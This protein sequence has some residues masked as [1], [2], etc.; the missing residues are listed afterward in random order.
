MWRIALIA[1]FVFMAIPRRTALAQSTVA[2]E[3]FVHY[4]VRGES[5]WRIA[6]QRYCAIL[7]E[8]RSV[9]P[10][11]LQVARIWRVIRRSNRRRGRLIDPHQ[12][13]VGLLLRLPRVSGFSFASAGEPDRWTCSSMIAISRQ[14]PQPTDATQLLGTDERPQETVV[15]VPSPP[16]HPPPGFPMTQRPASVSGPSGSVGSQIA[17]GPALFAD[18]GVGFRVGL[19]SGIRL[20]YPPEVA[21]FEGEVGISPSQS[22]SWYFTAHGSRSSA[23]ATP[24][25]FG[26]ER[27]SLVRETSLGFRGGYWLWQPGIVRIGPYV[28]L[29]GI[30]IDRKV[31]LAGYDLDESAF[32][33]GVEAGAAAVACIPLPLN[34]GGLLGARS[35]FVF[36]HVPINDGASDGLWYQFDLFA[37]VGSR[38]SR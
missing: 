32:G 7:G 9:R 23:L 25:I 13:P 30:W 31:A 2:V 24:L 35:T 6:E 3:P 34:M 19:L 4:V 33:F 21:V 22:R 5:F 28:G 18:I 14:T 10:T 37:G 27:N 38:C 17:R 26:N 15:E 36:R 16:S 20:D 12:L 29:Q 11:A 1:I 8:G